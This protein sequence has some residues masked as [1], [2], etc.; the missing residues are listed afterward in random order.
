MDETEDLSSRTEQTGGPNSSTMVRLY[1]KRTTKKIV[2]IH[3]R[4][5][6][7]SFRKFN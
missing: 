7:G 3:R 5:E 2:D 1:L 6:G 4:F